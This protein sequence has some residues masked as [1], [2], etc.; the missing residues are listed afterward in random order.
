M[1]G[2]MLLTLYLVIALAC[3]LSLE[4]FIHILIAF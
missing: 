2:L 4:Y 3:E 1:E